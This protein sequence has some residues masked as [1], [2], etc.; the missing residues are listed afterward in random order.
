MAIVKKISGI[1]MKLIFSG[2]PCLIVD[3]QRK[4]S[5]VRT[6]KKSKQR[7]KVAFIVTATGKKETPVVDISETRSSFVNYYQV[8]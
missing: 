6:E 7:I 3:F 1:S 8:A 2:R 4:E 5:N